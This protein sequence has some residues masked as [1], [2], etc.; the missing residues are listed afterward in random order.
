MNDASVSKKFLGVNGFLSAFL[1]LSGFPGADG[2]SGV[3]GFSGSDGLSRVN[4]FLGVNE[5]C[6][7]GRYLPLVRCRSLHSPTNQDRRQDL[8]SFSGYGILQIDHCV[9]RVVVLGAG[10]LTAIHLIDIV[11]VPSYSLFLCNT[12]SCTNLRRYLPRYGARHVVLYNFSLS[13]HSETCGNL[14]IY[15]FLAIVIAVMFLIH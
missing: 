3:E 10:V 13:C 1:S 12:Q 4:G 9:R 15:W 8:A 7:L 2:L 11:L 14:P 5:S 6:Q